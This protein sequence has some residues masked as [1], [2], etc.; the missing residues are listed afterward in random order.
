MRLKQ[1]LLIHSGGLIESQAHECIAPAMLQE[2]PPLVTSTYF[3]Q[4]ST[5]EQ[6]NPH[7]TR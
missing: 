4:I 1:M 3:S 2:A 5:P 7:Q 6:Q